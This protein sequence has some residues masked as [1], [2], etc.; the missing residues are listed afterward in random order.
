MKRS[1]S[2]I[3]SQDKTIMVYD[4]PCEYATSSRQIWHLL[5]S[6]TRHNLIISLI[7]Y[8][9]QDALQYIQLNDKVNEITNEQWLET[10]HPQRTRE[11]EFSINSG[12]IKRVWMQQG[13]SN[14]N[15]KKY[16]LIISKQSI[17][18]PWHDHPSIS[19]DIH[20]QTHKPTKQ[21]LEYLPI[22]GIVVTISP[23]LS[24][25]KMVVLPA[26][27]RPTIRIRISLLAKSRLN[28][29]VNVSPIF[30]AVDSYNHHTSI[31]NQPINLY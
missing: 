27:S 3:L 6:K 31:K 11:K 5:F 12:Y 16:W 9:M 4:L 8:Q 7:I 17:N 10:K 25:Y 18:W 2:W 15:L 13:K 29:F 14:L 26:A 1:S 30:L 23:S 21:D 19:T 20:N 28:S 24:L 22:V